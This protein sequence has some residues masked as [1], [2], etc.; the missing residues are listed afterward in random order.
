MNATDARIQSQDSYS[1][2]EWVIHFVAKATITIALMHLHKFMFSK[3]AEIPSD[4]IVAHNG[5]HNLITFQTTLR[6]SEAM[7]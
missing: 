7:I 1:L 6:R 4:S 3:F 2:I 5:N